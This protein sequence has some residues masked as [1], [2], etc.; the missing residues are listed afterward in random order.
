MK[1]QRAVNRLLSV[2]L[3]IIMVF[4]L[5]PTELAVQASPGGS[6]NQEDPVVVRNFAELKEALEAKEDLYIRV[7]EFENS[8][9]LDYYQLE[10]GKDYYQT[11]VAISTSNNFRKDLELNTFIDL[12]D[13]SN[14]LEYLISNYGELTIHGNGGIAFSIHRPN[15]K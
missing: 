8:E 9:G 13:K 6:G 5:L 2:I 14:G 1:K 12:R 11:S 15:F 4:E 10:E 3:A 7:D